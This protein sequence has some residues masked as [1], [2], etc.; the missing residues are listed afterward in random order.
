[1][2]RYILCLLLVCFLLGGCAPAFSCEDLL[3]PEIKGLMKSQGTVEETRAKIA[4]LYN[5]P[6]DHVP[7]LGEAIQWGGG[8]VSGW[9]GKPENPGL[10]MRFH[11]PNPSIENVLDCLGTP[12]FYSA[13]LYPTP[14]GGPLLN[15]KL[16]FTRQGI[17]TDSGELGWLGMSPTLERTDAIDDLYFVEPGSPEETLK[18]LTP[19]YSDE[20]RTRIKPWPGSWN[21]LEIDDYLH[22][23]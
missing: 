22:G 18:R 19:T 1:M 11:G 14:D 7:D 23:Q 16:Y 6:L 2:V 17:S 20:D 8:S 3:E 5:L 9:L 15:F 12:D 13:V 21:G 4:E 10:L